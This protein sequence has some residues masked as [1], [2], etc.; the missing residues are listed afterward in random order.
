MQENQLVMYFRRKVGDR[1]AFLN[2]VRAHVIMMTEEMITEESD[3]FDTLIV[4]MAKN[5]FDHAHSQGHLIIRRNG[6]V[7]EFEIKDDG[8]EAHDFES[9]AIYSVSA[10]N[11]INYGA[12]LETIRDI[13]FVLRIN[14]EI[15]T[16]RGFCYRGSYIP[17]H[18]ERGIEARKTMHQILESHVAGD[19]DDQLFSWI[20]RKALELDIEPNSIAQGVDTYEAAVHRW[21]RGGSPSHVNRRRVLEVIKAELTPVRVFDASM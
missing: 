19:I 17:L 15:D 16:S 1:D 6:S 4:E 21:A 10:G 12:G 11:G 5:I 8:T 13:A 9:C 2:N 18:K 20:V 14:L 3:T 7:L